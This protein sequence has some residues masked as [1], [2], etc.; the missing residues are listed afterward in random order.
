MPSLKNANISKTSRWNATGLSIGS[1]YN[2]SS[3]LGHLRVKGS[4][5]INYFRTRD[6]TW[7]CPKQAEMD[8]P[9]SLIGRLNLRRSMSG[10]RFHGSVGWVRWGINDTQQD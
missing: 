5:V 6:I 7:K 9:V 10:F 1:L 2:L 8:G 4:P 3:K